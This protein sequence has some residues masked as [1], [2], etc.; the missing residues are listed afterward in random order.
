MQWRRDGGAEAGGVQDKQEGSQDVLA[1][2]TPFAGPRPL[3][4]GQA[5]IP[6]RPTQAQHPASQPP[7]SEEPRTAAAGEPDQATGPHTAGEPVQATHSDGNGE[8]HELVSAGEQAAGVQL[9]RAG[10]PIEAT[11]ACTAELPDQ[12]TRVR[13]VEG[14]CEATEVRDFIAQFS[15]RGGVPV[16][17]AAMLEKL[18]G[19]PGRPLPAGLC[20][21]LIKLEAALRGA[22]LC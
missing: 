8:H 10:E 6:L 18:T 20:E 11:D 2:L 15:G 19:D 16:L 7:Q 22:E 4:T 13:S 5:M 3:S 1:L 9:G 12:A 17:G 21:A 14:P